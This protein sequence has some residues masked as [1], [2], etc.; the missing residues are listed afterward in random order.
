MFFKVKFLSKKI[1]MTIHYLLFIF[2]LYVQSRFKIGEINKENIYILI[3]SLFILTFIHIKNR[4]FDILGIF[5]LSG[6]L[7]QII[8][9]IYKLKDLK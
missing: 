1:I 7:F 5:L 3:F 2:A 6:F 4:F 9:W 8:Y